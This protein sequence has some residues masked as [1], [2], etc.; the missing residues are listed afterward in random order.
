[1][2]YKISTF[3]ILV[4]IM[5]SCATLMNRKQTYFTI[6]TS[7]P[8]YLVVNSD[9]I[10][11][12]ATKNSFYFERS[13]NSISVTAFIDTL[14]KSIDIK[15]K[16]SFNYWLNFY[17]SLHFWTGFY[18]DTKTKRRYTYPLMVYIDFTKNDSSYLTY[19]PLSQP[20]NR[21]ANILKITPLKFVGLV[22]PAVELSYE[23]KTGKNFSTQL[24]ASYL[25]RTSLI[26]GFQP[27][28][29]GYKVAI[30]EKFYFNKS[31]LQGRYLGLEFSFM[32]NKNKEIWQFGEADIYNNPTAV[33]TNYTDT[34]GINKQMYRLHLKLGY[35]YIYKRFAIDVFAGLGVRYKNTTHFD[36]INPMD[37]MERPR[38][39]NFNYISNREGNY[40][41]I[42]SV[43][44]ARIGWTF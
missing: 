41:Y 43:L 33:L 27:D 39:I 12:L 31:A 7:E 16:N 40:W 19:K 44:N 18:I 23:R 21:Y 5:S 36:R 1:M 42:S 11:K 25:L 28:L 13:K 10:P 15:A 35:Q 38:H 4:S 17:P 24:M 26:Y 20:Y 9:T 22:N 29:E 30:E 6:I 2:I 14:V 34:F 37:E 3:L 32:H 8:S